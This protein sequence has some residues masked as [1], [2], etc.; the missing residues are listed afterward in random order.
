MP[1]SQRADVETELKRLEL[2]GVIKKVHHSEWATPF[3][4]VLKDG[5]TRICGDYKVTVNPILEVDQY[6]FPKPDDLFASLSGGA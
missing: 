6:P 2:Q 4:P 3:V 5:H 1:Y